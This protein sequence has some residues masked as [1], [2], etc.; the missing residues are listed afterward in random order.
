MENALTRFVDKYKR[1]YTLPARELLKK[2]GED[3]TKPHQINVRKLVDKAKLGNSYYS[4]SN[5]K[6]WKKLIDKKFFYSVPESFKKDEA[7]MA[8][9]SLI[10]VGIFHNE[11]MID[12]PNISDDDIYA[13]A[14]IYAAEL[15][16]PEDAV[17]TMIKQMKPIEEMMDVFKAPK[18]CVMTKIGCIL[19][20][21]GV[22]I[23]H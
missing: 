8:F 15:M 5:L 9:S 23:T 10:C 19:K 1:P 7:A 21:Y 4:E 20:K 3:L 22:N 2:C 11:E 18:F 12:A 6:L 13:A 14:V 17:L 16:C